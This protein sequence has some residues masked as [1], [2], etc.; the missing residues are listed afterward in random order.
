MGQELKQKKEVFTLTKEEAAE[1]DAYLEK[2]GIRKENV[3]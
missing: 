1:M 3:S 2:M